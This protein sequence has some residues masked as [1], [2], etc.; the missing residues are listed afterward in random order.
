MW[1]QHPKITLRDLSRYHRPTCR[2]HAEHVPDH[3]LCARAKI[4][5]GQVASR[6]I[7][8]ALAVT[9]EGDA[10]SANVRWATLG[11]SGPYHA[12]FDTMLPDTT[13][14]ADAFHLVKLANSKLDECRRRV[15]EETFGYR[16][17]KSDPPYRR[18]RER[19]GTSVY[20]PHEKDQVAAVGVPARPVLK[21]RCGSGSF[22]EERLSGCRP[23]PGRSVCL[24]QVL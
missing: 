16:G 14:I 9:C 7:Y 22:L 23:G 10:W 6:L 18:C 17:C 21:P 3:A 20:S 4:D 11:L 8:V 2:R 12:V 5:D 1:Q 15:Q 19:G 24:H 13:Q